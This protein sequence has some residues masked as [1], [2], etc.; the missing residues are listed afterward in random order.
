MNVNWCKDVPDNMPEA[1]NIVQNNL[2]QNL[3]SPFKFTANSSSNLNT[4]LPVNLINHFQQQQS[5]I[6]QNWKTI[7]NLHQASNCVGPYK[8]KSYQDSE[9]D[10]ACFQ[11]PTKQ[12]ATEEKVIGQFNKLNLDEEFEDDEFNLTLDEDRNEFDDYNQDRID[13][14]ERNLLANNKD[15]RIQFELADEVQEFWNSNCDDVI[16]KLVKNEREKN[17]KAV[18]LW[19]PR[20]SFPTDSANDGEDKKKTKKSEIVDQTDEYIV[21]EDRI[22]ETELI[23][24]QNVANFDLEITEIS[25]LNSSKSSFND[26]DMIY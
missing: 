23:A 5:S 2:D 22:E 3:D 13:A 8:R 20:V 19:Q 15:S 16:T 14:E 21:F 24:K 12:N 18:I 10:L 1:F 11:P 26:E 9:D 6:S 25:D 7:T 17:S 4:S